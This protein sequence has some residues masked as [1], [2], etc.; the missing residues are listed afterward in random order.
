MK[1]S[2]RL[3]RF[4]QVDDLVSLDRRREPGAILAAVVQLDDLERSIPECL[5]AKLAASPDVRRDEVHV[6][7]PTNPDPSSGPAL[8]LVQHR[9]P[10]AFRWNIALS[11]VVDLERS[12]VRIGEPVCRAMTEVAVS[13][14]EPA[15][16][17]F[18]VGDSSLERFFARRA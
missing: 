11:L 17:L 1:A 18:Q 8:G 7:D 15:S 13:P 12:A 9:R 4:Q 3:H 16:L 5:F 14:A 10:K 6:F 2:A